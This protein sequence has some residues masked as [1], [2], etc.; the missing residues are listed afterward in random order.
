LGLRKKFSRKN[1]VFNVEP[2]SETNS[3]R[4]SELA[5]HKVYDGSSHDGG[6]KESKDSSDTAVRVELLDSNEN[7]TNITH[8]R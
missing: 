1:R 8:Q 3:P 4:T 6:N 5:A 2:V 7:R